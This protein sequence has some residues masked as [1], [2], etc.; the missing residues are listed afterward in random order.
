MK[1]SLTTF[2]LAL[3]L[4]AAP[5]VSSASPGPAAAAVFE[6]NKHSLATLVVTLKQNDNEKRAEIA[7]TTL[8]AEGTFATSLTALEFGSNRPALNISIGPDGKLRRG[9]KPDFV[10]VALL[11]EGDEFD[12]EVTLKDPDRDIAIV[13]LKEGTEPPELHAAGDAAAPPEI[14]DDLVLLQ[15]LP[16]KLNRETIPTLAEVL[17]VIPRPRDLY[18][19]SRGTPGSPAFDLEGKFVG[20]CTTSA[21]DP[22]GV[23]VNQNHLVVIPAATV[24]KL[25]TKAA[26]SA[27]E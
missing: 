11:V 3:A 25:T 16:A 5:A 19:V 14:L 22:G 10:S 4:A 7:A 18:V 17:A 15:K 21:G 9:T 2:S 24:T 1:T 26:E 23:T 13:Q 20:V 8:D 27:A 12:A 6:S